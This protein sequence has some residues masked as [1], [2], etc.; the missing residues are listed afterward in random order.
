MKKTKTLIVRITPEQE[1]V[2]KAVAN[3]LGINGISA[4]VRYIL[5]SG[6]K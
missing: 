3:E 5:F 1:K 2:L 4:C 6:G